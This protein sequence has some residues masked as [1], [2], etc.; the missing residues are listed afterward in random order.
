[1]ARQPRQN[2]GNAVYDVWATGL[3]EYGRN[4]SRGNV[5]FKR[6]NAGCTIYSYGS[7]FPLGVRQPNGD[8][9]LNGD[10]YGPTTSR[11]QAATRTAAHKAILRQG[12]GKILI[13]PFRSL[14]GPSQTSAYNLTIVDVEPDRNIITPCHKTH[15]TRGYFQRSKNDWK[16]KVFVRG[17][18]S[19]P[20]ELGQAHKHGQHLMGRAV[21]QVSTFDK[22]GHCLGAKYFISGM[23]ETAR[24]AWRSHFLSE[25]PGP[26]FTVAQAIESLK[27]GVVQDYQQQNI[28]AGG[29]GAISQPDVL[30][31]GEWFF[32]PRPNVLTKA[33]V[34]IV[35]EDAMALYR[36]V[37]GDTTPRKPI[38]DTLLPIGPGA[39]GRRSHRVTELRQDSTGQ[40]Y[41]RGTVTHTGNEHKRLAL[42]KVWHTVHMNTAKG[43][44]SGGGRV[45]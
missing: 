4:H 34:P 39:N 8:F 10:T 19:T 42:G 7:H 24:N 6:D 27:P 37:S 17:T 25:L 29:K 20:E 45:D 15:P 3:N 12:H 11:H 23:D 5:Y 28:L 36:T 21:F 41:A 35:R 26:A 22:L 18:P 9:I 2:W 32:I 44:W 14:S 31:Q 16:R 13:V 1:M 43:S 38:L 40:L 33:L 30:R